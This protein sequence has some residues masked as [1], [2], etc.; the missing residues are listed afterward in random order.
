MPFTAKDRP[1]PSGISPTF[2]TVWTSDMSLSLHG[3]K[4]EALTKPVQAPISVASPVIS[5]SLQEPVLGLSPALRT[6]LRGTSFGVV[7]QSWTRTEWCS[8]PQSRDSEP[9]GENV[10]R[11]MATIPPEKTTM[12]TGKTLQSACGKVLCI[13]PESR[14]HVCRSSHS[15]LSR[16]RWR[17]WLQ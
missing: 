4:Q 2:A 16:R 11:R 5:R 8:P 12:K 9:P 15:V 3:R 13:V 1:C 6:N 10:K 17:Q 7:I 14:D